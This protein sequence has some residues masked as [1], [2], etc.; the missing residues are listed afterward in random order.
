MSRRG[1]KRLR[2]WNLVPGN[3]AVQDGLRLKSVNR[4]SPDL[5]LGDI[6]IFPSNFWTRSDPPAPSRLP[7]QSYWGYLLILLGN[8]VVRNL[9]SHKES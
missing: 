7:R 3:G 6:I 8:W 2:A 9:S 4:Q 1:K 5:P